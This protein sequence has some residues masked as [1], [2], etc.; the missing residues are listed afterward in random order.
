MQAIGA[1]E[2]FEIF[3]Q[4]KKPF[5]ILA[6]GAVAIDAWDRSYHIRLAD[7]SVLGNHLK[8]LIHSG[9][10]ASATGSSHNL[11]LRQDGSLWGSG[12]NDYGAL[13]LGQDA[14]YDTAVL[15]FQ[16]EEPM[17]DIPPTA[18]AGPDLE[19]TDRNNDGL[20]TAQ[21]DASRSTDD[22]QIV[23]WNWSWVRASDGQAMSIDSNAPSIT[24]DFEIGETVVTLTVF[25]NEGQ[26]SSDELRIVIREGET[27]EKWIARYFTPVQINAML[28]NPRAADSDGD[29]YSN[30]REFDIGIDPTEALNPLTESRLSLSLQNGQLYLDVYPATNGLEYRIH[31]NRGFG[32]WQ[33]FDLPHTENEGK[34][35]FALPRQNTRFF[36]VEIYEP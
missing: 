1:V 13:G 15:L 6:E 4:D 17:D 5:E 22:W 36:K 12:S 21:L 32:Y 34:L 16:A 18:D 24:H 28:P 26:S 2:G 33:V 27:F 30:Q 23:S 20:E 7:G 14:Q 31:A 8:P 10:F 25:D 11:F 3:E 35:R 29:G 9:V 19:L